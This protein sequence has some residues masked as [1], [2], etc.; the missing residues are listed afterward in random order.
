MII[1]TNTSHISSDQKPIGLLH[2]TNQQRCLERSRHPQLA[3]LHGS[4][5]HR[6]QQWLSVHNTQRTFKVNVS[7]SSFNSGSRISL[8]VYQKEEVREQ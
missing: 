1:M 2:N 4:D 5:F 6:K 3:H 8:P 7:D